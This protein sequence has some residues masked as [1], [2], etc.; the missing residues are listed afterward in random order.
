MS[1]LSQQ[2]TGMTLT[3]MDDMMSIVFVGDTTSDD[4]WFNTII[5][6]LKHV[7]EHISEFYHLNSSGEE[8]AYL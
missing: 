1:V 7:V 2:N 5:H 3:S 4:E 8:A 6:E